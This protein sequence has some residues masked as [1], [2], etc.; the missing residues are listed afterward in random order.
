M[1]LSSGSSYSSRL[2]MLKAYTGSQRKQMEDKAIPYHQRQGAIS[3]QGIVE[4]D[5]LDVTPCLILLFHISFGIYCC[6]NE[7]RL[8]FEADQSFLSIHS[9]FLR[10]H[11]SFSKARNIKEQIN[12]RPLESI[13]QVFIHA[14]RLP[15]NFKILVEIVLV[16]R[17]SFYRRYFTKWQ[18]VSLGWYF[19][20]KSQ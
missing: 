12:K 4:G 17:D 11:F 18:D 5:L 14:F 19:S 10:D 6:P 8:E 7:N 9:T 16:K 3:G 15:T 2:W 1:K 13:F 20:Y